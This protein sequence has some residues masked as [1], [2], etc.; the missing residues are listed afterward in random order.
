M[1]VKDNFIQNTVFCKSFLAHIQL[2]TV[3]RQDET[4]QLCF[5]FALIHF[6]LDAFCFVFFIYVLQLFCPKRVGN[7]IVTVI[8]IQWAVCLIEYLASFTVAGMWNVLPLDKDRLAVCYCFQS[9]C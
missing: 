6:G 7:K 4:D 3:K 8:L 1:C 9:S 2:N 5:K